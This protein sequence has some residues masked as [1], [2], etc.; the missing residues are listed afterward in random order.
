MK[1]YF[2]ILC[3]SLIFLTMGSCKK[4]EVPNNTN[5]TNNNNNPSSDKRDMMANK[6]DCT[7]KVYSKAGSTMALMDT[8]TYEITVQK[9][10]SDTS[11]IKIL[12]NDTLIVKGTNVDYLSGD[13]KTLVFDITAQKYT[14]LGLERDVEGD[15]YF[16]TGSNYKHGGYVDTSKTLKF[17]F[18]HPADYPG[19]EI[20]HRFDAVKK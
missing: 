13:N 4:D 17:A 2:G 14:Y 6:Y 10:D 7:H 11:K 1:K 19:Y 15:L 12:K 9:D 20:V 8:N 3:F 16:F 5:N 18:K